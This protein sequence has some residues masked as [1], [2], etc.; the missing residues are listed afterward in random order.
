MHEIF[1]TRGA[2]DDVDSPER[3]TR[4]YKP[5]GTCGTFA[6]KRPPKLNIAKRNAYDANLE[7][8][9]IKKKEQQAD[10][11]KKQGEGTAQDKW[12]SLA[13]W[14]RATESVNSDAIARENKAVV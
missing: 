8:H 10:E 1:A 9:K 2:H 7:A 14:A 5:R 12:R 13:H 3:T 4:A 11:K 6:G